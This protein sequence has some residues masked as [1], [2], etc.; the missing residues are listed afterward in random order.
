MTTPRLLSDRDALDAAAAA[1][2]SAG[3]DPALVAAHRPDTTLACVD[4]RSLAARGSLWWSEAP[5]LQGERIGT[6]GHFWARDAASARL[7]LDA[8]ASRLAAAGASLAIGPMDGTTWRRYRWI[9]D[10]GSEPPFLLEPDNPDEFPIWWTAA[11]FTSLAGYSSALAADLSASDPRVPA[12]AARLARDG[13]TLRQLSTAGFDDDLRALHAVSS[14]AFSDA[15]LFTPLAEGDFV[16]QYAALRQRIDTRFV[17]LAG[18][19]DT[20][21]GFIFGIPDL[22]RP[23]R[24]D[25]MDTLVGKTIAVLPGRRFAGLGAVLVDALHRAARDAGF[26]RVIHALR[27]DG[28]SASV[29]LSAR[30]VHPIRR[31]TLFAR[32]LGPPAAP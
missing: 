31:Y 13:V 11:G 12:A 7:L 23:A 32:R 4:G 6:I 29:N 25:P 28:N 19:N 26:T 30:H 15:F 22:L 3:L 24:G 20:C 18:L 10:R 5:P 9:T 1:P 14:T 8:A 21:V 16:A 27:H 2:G 17:I